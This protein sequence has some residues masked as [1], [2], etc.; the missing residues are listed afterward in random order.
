MPWAGYS[1]SFWA[2]SPGLLWG[3][4]VIEP[5]RYPAC[6][7]CS[8]QSEP[9]YSTVQAVWSVLQRIPAPMGRGHL[10]PGAHNVGSTQEGSQKSLQKMGHPCVRAF[11][12]RN[13]WK[14]KIN[15]EWVGLILCRFLEKA[16]FQVGLKQRIGKS[17]EAGKQGRERV[18]GLLR[19]GTGLPKGSECESTG[20]GQ[21]TVCH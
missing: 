16:E 21:A 10:F 3:W 15:S 20:C 7:D 6:D 18:L 5:V 4:N 17:L 19:R 14:V 12:V 11:A 8:V 1:A 13:I 9:Q 2:Q